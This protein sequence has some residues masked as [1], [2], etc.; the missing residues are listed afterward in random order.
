M[1]TMW[2][3]KHRG[4]LAGRSMSRLQAGGV[5]LS[6]LMFLAMSAVAFSCGNILTSTHHTG[7]PHD[8][9]TSVLL[10]KVSCHQLLTSSYVGQGPSFASILSDN[11]MSG[12]LQV[13]SLVKDLHDAASLSRG[14][15]R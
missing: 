15:P 5:L 4:R 14:P 10:C 8:H 9:A 6:A 11:S 12:S 3:D 7:S 1:F 2:L 13:V